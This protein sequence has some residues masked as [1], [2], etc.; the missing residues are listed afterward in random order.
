MSELGFRVDRVGHA[1]D[2]FVEAVARLLPQL[3][4]AP[5]PSIRLGFAIPGRILYPAADP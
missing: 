3:S 5:I 1:G 4:G 2:E